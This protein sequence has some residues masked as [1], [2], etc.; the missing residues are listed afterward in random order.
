[1]GEIRRARRTG[2]LPFPE[3]V[4]Q[5]IG[6][7]FREAKSWDELS[8]RL[9]R[10][11]YRIEPTARGMTITDGEWHAKAS[12][13]DPEGSRFKLEERFGERLDGYLQRER[14]TNGRMASPLGPPD[15]Y[16]EV[17]GR[18]ALSTPTLTRTGAVS[19]TVDVRKLNDQIFGPPALSPTMIEA[20]HANRAAAG[21]EQP[22][23]HTVAA[24]IGK[25]SGFLPNHLN[26]PFSPAREV[27]L[28]QSGLGQS[29]R[30]G[31]AGALGFLAAAARP[32]SSEEAEKDV[33]LRGVETGLR[34]SVA[35]AESRSERDN[36]DGHSGAT[37]VDDDPAV[38][39]L[40]RDAEA[41]KEAER[42]EAALGKAIGEY[43][44]LEGKIREAAEL[45]RRARAYEKGFDEHL[46]RTYQDADAAKAAFL[47]LSQQQSSVQTASLMRTDPERFGATRAAI[48]TKWLGLATE[49]N[50]APAYRAARSAADYGEMHVNALSRLPHAAKRAAW[51]KALVT[52]GREVEGLQRSISGPFHKDRLLH[53]I[54]EHAST[55]SPERLSRAQHLFSPGALSTGSACN[56]ENA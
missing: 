52:T 25:T 32:I 19:P 18:P 46:A 48:R 4:R 51:Q 17:F 2:E 31:T 1:M 15:I 50:K 9:I 5:D 3:Q 39:A 10:Y 30:T 20:A 53:R 26:R 55:L 41:Y 56:A 23:T 12:G 38:K 54:A 22:L 28:G 27:D 47:T 44:A 40:V 21:M 37:L 16:H 7:T 35:L 42:K 43:A 29:D 6:A 34:A 13:I 24:P 36:S 49:T 11:G 14:N 45:E 33:V 8:Q